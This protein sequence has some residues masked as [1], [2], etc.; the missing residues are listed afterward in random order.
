MPTQ[1]PDLLSSGDVAALLGISTARVHSLAQAGEL[2]SVGRTRSG[3]IFSRSDVSA[4]A[5]RR[6][7]QARDDWRVRPP[8]EAA[9]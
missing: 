9:R 6:A 8:V 2:P 7:E 1:V 3:R 5:H 4:L